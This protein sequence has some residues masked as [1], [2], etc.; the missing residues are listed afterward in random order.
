MIESNQA[1]V[2]LLLR[3][4]LEMI[5]LIAKAAKASKDIAIDTLAVSVNLS[6]PQFDTQS[7]TLVAAA[8]DADI[9]RYA[10]ICNKVTTIESGVESKFHVWGWQ[11]RGILIT[12]Y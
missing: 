9:R 8:D 6:S 1:T 12:S 7:S 5:V 10:R 11:L 3:L 2:L 4:Y